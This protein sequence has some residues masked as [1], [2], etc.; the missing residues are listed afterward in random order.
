MPS[1]FH[2]LDAWFVLQL[3]VG[4]VFLVARF[5]RGRR[6]RIPLPPGPKPLPIL[7]NVFDLPRKVLASEYYKLHERYGDVVYL[8]V[9]GQS[10]VLLGSY[11][12][13]RE[14]M[15]KRSSNYSNR[16]RSI[17]K[18]LIGGDWAF[19]FDQYDS[20]WRR[21]RKAFHN[22][23]GSKPI[24][25][26]ESVQEDAARRLLQDV[27]A[28]PELFADYFRFAFG[29]TI[30][31]V[32]YGITTSSLDDEL[33]A[34]VEE[35]QVISNK[36]YTPG[37]YL[38]ELLPFLRHIPAW[39]PGAQFKRDAIEWNVTMQATRNKPFDV[40]V[41]KIRRGDATPSIVS[42]IVEGAF[43]K[44]GLSPE[45]ESITR[46]ATAMAYFG[47]VDTVQ[48][49]SHTFLCAMALFPEVQK[50]AQSELDTIVGS[51]RLPRFSDRSSLP[52]V[53]ALVYECLRWKPTAQL[54][55]PHR[56]VADDEFNGYVIPGGSL[57]LPNVWAMARDPKH[58]PDPDSFKPERFLTADGRPKEEVLHPR[59]YAFGFG[60]R[61]CPGNH[62]GEATLFITFAT[63]LHALIVELQPDEKG[64]SKAPA[65]E[66][67][68][69]KENF[70]T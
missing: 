66:D 17:M 65:S 61:I 2:G 44:G 52:Y 68:R 37:K 36:A 6:R 64:L 12:T 15:D 24:A 59:D 31:R 33:I 11:E 49:T 70:L 9:L 14:L 41:E 55:L 63:I 32:V 29:S 7:G 60:R 50:K 51:S 58:Y 28:K 3:A 34:V 40:A 13:A 27:L 62:F 25:Q 21:R 45:E 42:S 8:N 18:T 4:V 39:V 35:A 5:L 16:P 20:L 57:I 26:Y 23:F 43:S 56:S 67:V 54:G 53:N 30:L 48:A 10:M 22:H 69:M 46:D 19:V 1:S 38:V 47:A